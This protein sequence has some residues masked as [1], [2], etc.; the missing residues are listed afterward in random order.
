MASGAAAVGDASAEASAP[1][2][3]IRSINGC[4]RMIMPTADGMIT[5]RM[6]RR[7]NTMRWREATMSPSAQRADS[8]GVTALMTDTAITP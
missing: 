6:L 1:W 5:A 8:D 3:R 2:S 4:A 7:P